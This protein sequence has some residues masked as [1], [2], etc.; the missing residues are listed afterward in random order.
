MVATMNAAM[1][2]PSSESCCERHTGL[3]VD[4]KVNTCKAALHLA[5]TMGHPKCMRLLLDYG[6]DP[7]LGASVWT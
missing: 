3:K 7:S 5:A 2:Q 1:S 6:A 4:M